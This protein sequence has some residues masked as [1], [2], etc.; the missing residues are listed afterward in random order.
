MRIVNKSKKHGISSL[1]FQVDSGQ[2]YY[3]GIAPQQTT[4][5][6]PIRP[7]YENPS[8]QVYLCTFNTFGRAYLQPLRAITIDHTGEKKITEGR[9]TLTIDITGKDDQIDIEFNIKQD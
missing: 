7:V 8:Y 2:I 1:S 4:C 3:G 9:C 6:F 5:Y